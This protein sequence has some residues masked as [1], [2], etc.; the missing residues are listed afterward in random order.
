MGVRGDTRI[1]SH[2]EKYTS[3]LEVWGDRLLAGLVDGTLVVFTPAQPPASADSP[4]Q[5]RGP[6]AEA[7]T[8]VTLCGSNQSCLRELDFKQRPDCCTRSRAAT[9]Y[10]RCERLRRTAL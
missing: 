4:W 6:P 1:I 5:V 2:A 7:E 10:A 8:H 9:P 3:T